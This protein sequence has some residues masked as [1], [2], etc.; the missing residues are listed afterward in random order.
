MQVSNGWDETATR[1]EIL[2]VLATVDIH[3]K[4]A[5]FDTNNFLKSMRCIVNDEKSVVSK[6]GVWECENRETWS[7]FKS[8]VVLVGDAAHA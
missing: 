3:E 4:N 2:D 8:R 6:W 5:D 1:E 7:S